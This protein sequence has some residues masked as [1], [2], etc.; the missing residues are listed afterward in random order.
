MQKETLIGWIIVLFGMTGFGL[1]MAGFIVGS[2][3]VVTAGACMI[4]VTLIAAFINYKRQ[5]P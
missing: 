4:A 1:Y 3:V 5:V 2:I